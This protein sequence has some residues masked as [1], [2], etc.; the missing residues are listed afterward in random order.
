MYASSGDDELKAKANGMVAE[1]AKCQRAHGDGYLSAFPEEFF[2]RLRDG[3]KVWAPFYTLHKIMA[4]LLDVHVHCGNEQA[5]EV[6]EGMA[7]WVGRWA[8][9]L[10]DEQMQGVMETEFGGTAEV[11]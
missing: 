9:P 2:A 6:A 1:L 8:Q 4:G 10:S 3:K 11:L 7:N 5:L